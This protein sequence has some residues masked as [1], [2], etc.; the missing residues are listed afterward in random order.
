MRNLEYRNPSIGDDAYVMTLRRANLDAMAGKA[1]GTINDHR[2]RTLE[3]VRNAERINKTPTLEPRGPFPLKDQVGMGLAVDICQKSLVA[4]GKIEAVVQAETL[5]KLRSTYT[6]NWE[7]SPRGVAESGAF[8][9]GTGRVRPT[10]CP[11][12][13]EWYQDNWRGVESRM[14]FKSRANH[15][16]TMAAM[17]KA[18]DYVRR[19]AIA[20]ETVVE[21]NYLWKFGAF[22]TVCTAASLRGF[23]GFYTDLAGLRGQQEKGRHGTVPHPLTKNTILTEEQCLDLPHIA[24]VLRGKFKGEHTIDQHAV[25]IAN[26]TSSGLEP[27]WWIDKLIEVNEEEGL[28]SGPAFSSPDGELIAHADYDASFR[29][30]LHLVQDT[31]GLIP[32][33]NDVDAMYGISRTPRKS[34]ASRAKRAGFDDKMDEM[35]R[36]RKVEAAQNRRVRYKMSML[37]SEAV[38]MM[39]TTW[40]VSYAL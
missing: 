5:R 21:T 37:Y 10:S 20:A 12:A 33:G 28:S 40:R 13:S 3:L 31:T 39:P 18:I 1:R 8:I 32:E 9:K 19:D 6:K 25:N 36:W 16:I 15:A 26:T 22:L 30:Y 29:T 35:N 23:E 27:R 4:K 17:V 24:V 7:S 2:L 38:L 34:A 11:A 14:G